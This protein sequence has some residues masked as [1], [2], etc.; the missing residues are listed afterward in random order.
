MFV[1]VS[2]ALLTQLTPARYIRHHEHPQ[3]HAVHLPAKVETSRVLSSH[4]PDP[5]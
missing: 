4:P 2:S 5:Q 3:P 1:L